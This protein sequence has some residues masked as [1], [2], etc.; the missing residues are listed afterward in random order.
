MRISTFFLLSET[1]GK[2]YMQEHL[3]FACICGDDFCMYFFILPVFFHCGKCS[4]HGAQCGEH[5]GNHGAV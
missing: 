2:E 1:G 5:G 3:V 4:V